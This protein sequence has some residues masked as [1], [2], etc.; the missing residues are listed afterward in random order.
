M[1]PEYWNMYQQGQQQ[2]YA[3]S[4]VYSGLFASTGTTASSITIGYD[5]LRGGMLTGVTAQDDEDNRSEDEKWL[6]G[7]IEEIC[8]AL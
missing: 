3:N 4:S 6:D 2:M 8:V 7:R 5:A 1:S